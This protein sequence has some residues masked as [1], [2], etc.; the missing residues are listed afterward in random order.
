MLLVL[1]ATFRDGTGGRCRHHGNLAAKPPQR[2]QGGVGASQESREKEVT[3]PLSEGSEG[4]QFPS[5][6]SVRKPVPKLTLLF[7]ISCGS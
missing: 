6:Q 7:L 3:V 4:F 5:G 2:I 1:V